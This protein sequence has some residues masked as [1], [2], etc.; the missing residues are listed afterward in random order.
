MAK[1]KWS[2]K[3]VANTMFRFLVGDP[4]GLPHKT[5]IFLILFALGYLDIYTPSQIMSRLPEKVIRK[6]WRER[7]GPFNQDP[8]GLKPT[9]TE[10][11]EFYGSWEW[12]KARMQALK[13]HGRRC[14][15]CGALPRQVSKS[16]PVA[17]HVDH[18]KPLSLYWSLR[19]HPENLQVLCH[20]CNKGKSN[21]D[22]TDWRNEDKSSHPKLN[23]W[24][25]Y[26]SQRD[27]VEGFT[28][29]MLMRMPP[30]KSYH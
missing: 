23:P 17:M 1:R 27:F 30:Q 5:V 13:R 18:I 21:W 14:Q 6:I 16:G 28:P 4:D 7:L 8:A 25:R 9:K 12:Q 29:Y 22:E 19:L 2:E 11:Q 3:E 15:C 20:E 26:H 10:K 24:W